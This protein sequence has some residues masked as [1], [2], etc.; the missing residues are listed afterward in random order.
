MAPVGIIGLGLLGGAI[1]ERFL[2]ADLALIGF[3]LDPSRLT[4][5]EAS[6]G[7]AA[8]SNAEVAAKCSR[9]VL[10]LPTS[11][12][13]AQVLH[14]IEHEYRHGLIII[15]TSTGDPDQTAELGAALAMREVA[16]LDASVS[17]SSAEA[18]Q[19]NAIVMAGGPRATFDICSDLFAT[20]ARRSFHLG[21]WGSG[22]RM[23]L[24]S[25]LVL[26][27]NRAALAE[28]LALA[29]NLGIDATECLTVLKEGA[30][31]S[32]A[33]DA[34]GEKMIRG[35]FSP[36]A[37]LSQ[38]LKDVRL[39]RTVAARADARVPFSTLHQELLE[40]LAASG[41]ADADNSAILRAFLP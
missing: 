11:D 40:R 5:F 6:R 12:V 17:G 14:E 1:A 4:A 18:R 41:L 30:A 2:G 23:K 3:D 33:M 9:V 39:I 16:Y 29:M 34:K 15:D 27:L 35:D 7:L 8:R 10:C 20:F 25:N 24:V 19:G 22:T 37:R 36:Q 21:P 26:G 38:H 13:V 32:K 28:G 31:Y